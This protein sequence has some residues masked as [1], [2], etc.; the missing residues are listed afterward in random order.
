MNH[1]R[2]GIQRA[3]RSSKC[4]RSHQQSHNRPRPILVAFQFWKVAAEES[5][6]VKGQSVTI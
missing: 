2:L 4:Q 6:N 3:H 5:Q 1:D